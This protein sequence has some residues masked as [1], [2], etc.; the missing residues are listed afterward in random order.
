MENNI[1]NELD[2]LF[3]ELVVSKIVKKM[4]ASL[5]TAIDELK[6]VSE[7]AGIKASQ[8]S[9]SEMEQCLEDALSNG[10]M[11]VSFGAYVDLQFGMLNKKL[12]ECKKE[13][14]IC[15]EKVSE[16]TA[17]L[18]DKIEALGQ[19]EHKLGQ[20]LPQ[21]SALIE[22]EKQLITSGNDNICKKLD[23]ANSLEKA[24]IMRNG[25][26]ISALKE[27]L[28]K[29]KHTSDTAPVLEK[30]EES[31]KLLR[32]ISDEK[33]INAIQEVK[34]LEKTHH[35]QQSRLNVVLVIT[36]I[37]SLLGIAAVIAMKFIFPL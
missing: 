29:I 15:E 16:I 11:E 9:V 19:F 18:G 36:N 6:Q 24:S 20:I 23:Y 26:N 1:T 17:D 8:A 33:T 14:K 3:D 10:N 7:Q 21:V 37:L 13:C 4:D 31:K 5:T 35:A 22:S 25:E 30:I 28:E 34:Q 2:T 32:A 12:D 27:E